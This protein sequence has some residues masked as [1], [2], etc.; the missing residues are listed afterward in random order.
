MI[1]IRKRQ[2]AVAKAARATPPKTADR[3]HDRPRPPSALTKQ[4][5]VGPGMSEPIG[6]TNLTEMF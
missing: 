1:S 4:R 3:Q 5:R 6:R 2:R